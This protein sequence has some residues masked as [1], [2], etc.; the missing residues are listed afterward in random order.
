[1]GLVNCSLC[2]W[3]FDPEDEGVVG[4]IGTFITAN[5]CGECLN[6]VL[7]MADQLRIPDELTDE[8]D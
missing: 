6:G 7:D 1:M 4:T 8:D 2:D 5:F 3:G